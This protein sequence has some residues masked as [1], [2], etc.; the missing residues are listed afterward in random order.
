VRTINAMF[1]HV[2]LDAKD[3][4]ELGN[5][6][7][8]WQRQ[9]GHQPDPETIARDQRRKEERAIRLNSASNDISTRFSDW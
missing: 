2:A 5:E 1:K 8:L 9:N 6:E 3:V 7:A 4:A